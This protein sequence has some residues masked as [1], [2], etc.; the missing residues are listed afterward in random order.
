[1]FSSE[2]LTKHIWQELLEI[3]KKMTYP[4]DFWKDYFCGNDL[5]EHLEENL[6]VITNQRQPGSHP[7]AKTA[8]FFIKLDQKQSRKN[9]KT[10]KTAIQQVTKGTWEQKDNYNGKK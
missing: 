3:L 4:T 6:H 2:L 1:M 10:T 5:L 7:S 9:R 8:W